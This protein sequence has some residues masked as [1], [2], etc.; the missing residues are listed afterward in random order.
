MSKV[1][2]NL[3]IAALS[4]EKG[5]M[6]DSLVYS[7]AI[8]LTHLK[9]FNNMSEAANAVRAVLDNGKALDKLKAASQISG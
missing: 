6:Y 7:G 3:G 1:A 2:A 5:T 8:C 4:G 9:R